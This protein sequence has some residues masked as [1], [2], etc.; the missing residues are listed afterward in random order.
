MFG[1]LFIHSRFLIDA[2]NAV[3][4]KPASH[5]F[6]DLVV[7]HFDGLPARSR[8]LDYG[9][10]ADVGGITAALRLTEPDLMLAD[11]NPDALFMATINAEFAELSSVARS[12]QR[13]CDI[14]HD[15][16]LIV[17]H[18]PFMIDFGRR[19]YRDGGSLYGGQLSLDWGMDGMSRLAPGGRLVMHTGASVVGKRDVLRDAFWDAM[20]ASGFTLD[21]Q[22]FG[23]DIFGEELSN[24]I[25]ADVDRIAAVGLRIERVP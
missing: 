20:P 18:P 12:I 16:D 13:P 24:P 11:I 23:P 25:Y 5:R 3:F 2:H 17:M 9:T 1:N 8:V 22:L 14:D 4:L 10:G 21:Y 19:T 6:A 15:F 7:R